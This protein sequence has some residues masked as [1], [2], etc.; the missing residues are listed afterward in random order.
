MDK[1]RGDLMSGGEVA[2]YL[3]MSRP[4][5]YK[6]AKEGGIPCQKVGRCWEFHKEEID[7]WRDKQNLRRTRQY[8]QEATKQQVVKAIKLRKHKHMKE[9]ELDDETTT[10]LLPRSAAVAIGDRVELTEDSAWVLCKN[11]QAQ[12]FPSYAAR[13]QLR[14][15]GLDLEFLI[16]EITEPEELAAYQALTQFHYRSRTLYGRTA[17]L[18]IRNF[19]PI[20]P[21][22][23]GYIELT[24]S[25]Y[26]N[27][28]RSAILNA[29]FQANNTAG[30]K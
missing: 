23:I 11:G 5:L 26:M 6:L 12:I 16:K 13:E 28:A 25:F 3:E 1:K 8:H 24:S 22:V 30:F 7:L 19:H 15:G 10:L 9:V 29:P 21:K 27:K 20:Y 18:I 17:P 4:S 2:K 14:V